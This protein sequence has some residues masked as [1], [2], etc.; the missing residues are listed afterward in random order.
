MTI[1]VMLG[2]LYMLMTRAG[3]P[4]TWRWLMNEPASGSSES[5]QA[6]DTAGHDGEPKS[7]SVPMVPTGPTDEDPEEAEA[8]REEFQA[9]T[10]GT[11]DLHIEEMPAYWRLMG[12]A[13][14]QTPA[15]LR[16]RSQRK[17]F[18]THLVQRPDEYRGQL[19]H[20]DLNVRRV[21]D[22]PAEKNGLG[23]DKLYEAWG[24]SDESRG[25]LYVVV[26]AHLPPGMPVGP[27]VSESVSV[28][29]YFMKLQGYH[30]A[31][32][33][34]HAP[35]LRAPLL[36]GRAVWHPVITPGQDNTTWFWITVVGGGT[37]LLLTIG[38]WAVRFR[39]R[40]CVAV[41]VSNSQGMAVERW[42]EQAEAGANEPSGSNGG[43][44]LSGE[45]FGDEWM[46]GDSVEEGE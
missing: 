14:R 23:I 36:I 32:A 34:P 10:D 18:Y 35:P 38:Q 41:H 43:D 42:L 40:S 9:I 33:K 11:T 39:Q 2:V 13:D 22:Y 5:S 29:G 30:E 15:M 4:G 8:A 26:F 1:I 45:P 46:R 16:Q 25:W 12:W 31:G 21:L 20:L 37:V 3:D 24:W 6:T 28:D 27:D 44:D 7:E 17:M 19:I